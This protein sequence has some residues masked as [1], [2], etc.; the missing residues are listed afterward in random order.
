MFFLSE[1]SP[2]FLITFE[3]RA[4]GLFTADDSSLDGP[5]KQGA[6]AFPHAILPTQRCS[7]ALGKSN[8]GR[9]LSP[10]ELQ[11]SIIFLY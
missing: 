7:L 2:A 8:P 11:L 1:T 6:W 9:L 5:A 10:R 3:F 4:G